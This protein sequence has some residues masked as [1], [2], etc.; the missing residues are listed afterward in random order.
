MSKVTVY[1]CSHDLQTFYIQE[2]KKR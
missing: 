2:A 1:K